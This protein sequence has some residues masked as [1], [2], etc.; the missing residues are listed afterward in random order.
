MSVSQDTPVVKKKR[1]AV[2]VVIVASIAVH[3][4]AGGVLAVIKI[5]EVLQ[6]EPEFEAPP[7]EAVE[8]PPPPP[9]PPPTTQ[10]T[11][12]SMPRPQPLAA[13]NPQNMDV[14]AIEIDRSNLNMLSGRGFGGGLGDIG[15]GVMDSFTSIKFFGMESSGGN[16]AILFDATHSGAGVFPRA[17]EELIKTIKQVDKAAGAQLAVMYFGGKE[18]GH[19]LLRNEEG[20]EKDFW[21]PRGVKEGYLSAGDPALKKIIK[22]LEDVGENIR[23]AM[24]RDRAA[25]EKNENAFFLLGT[26]Y[27]GALNEAYGLKADTV[28]LI[29]EPRIAFPSVGKVE[30]AF[31]RFEEYGR[32]KPSNTKVIIIATAKGDRL[33]EGKPAYISTMRAL[34][35]INGGD[36]SEKEKKD[37]F[38]KVTY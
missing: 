26:N 24:V 30:Q 22:E 27:W 37:L 1:G 21:Y 31:E 7:L 11:Q 10:R 32:R 4:L 16:V 5:T 38:N 8:P 33:D 3:L 29:A 28:Y 9:P 20:V 35:L 23:S 2:F 25:Y 19:V 13:Q 14:P 12:K 36:L 17:S 15:G 6:K 34:E 18:G